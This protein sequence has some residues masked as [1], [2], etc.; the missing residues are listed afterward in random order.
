M[1]GKLLFECRTG[2]GVGPKKMELDIQLH[3]CHEGLS[4]FFGLISPI[5]DSLKRAFLIK[6]F[7]T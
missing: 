2:L 6:V 4:L 1:M 7:V 5:E 3:A